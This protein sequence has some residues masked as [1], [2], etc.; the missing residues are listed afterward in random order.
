VKVSPYFPLVLCLT[1]AAAAPASAQ[2]YSWRAGNG[3]AVYSDHPPGTEAPSFRVIGTSFRSTRPADARLAT[4][5]DRLIEKH[6]ATYAVSPQLVRAVVQVESGF[7]PRAVSPKGA[8]GLMQLMPATAIEMGVGDVFDPDEN[9]RGG[10]AYLRQLL[11][12]YAGDERL[13]LAAY[14]AGP[15]AVDRHLSQVPPFRETQRYLSQVSSRA[16][17][18]YE[19]SQGVNG[20]S[21]RQYGDLATPVVV[22]RRATTVSRRPAARTVPS[23]PRVYRSWETTADGRVIQKYSDTRPAAGT[24]EIVR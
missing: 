14:N 24:Y 6:A 13:A 19:S 21:V 2:I 20:R 9:I 23:P 1:V 18:A 10:V 15:Q 17:R 12:R 4:S 8:S 16:G 22:G 5:Y 11:N 3:N 7:N